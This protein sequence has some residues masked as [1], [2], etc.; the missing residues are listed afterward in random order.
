MTAELTGPGLPTF[1]AVTFV[2]PWAPMPPWATQTGVIVT[3]EQSP[4]KGFVLAAR[5]LQGGLPV[6]ESVAPTTGTTV[7]I[8]PPAPLSAAL[9]YTVEV[10]WIK[11]NTTPEWSGSVASAPLVTAPVRLL[12]GTV[13]PQG[14]TLYWDSGGSGA[15]A[16]FYDQEPPPQA[17]IKPVFGATGSVDF[18]W[19]EGSTYS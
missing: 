13:T 10:Q 5:L 4:P 14:I 1:K 6:I 7:E 2:D 16:K 8:V 15:E 3:V 12:A 17:R 19:Q 9:R 18:S 11:Q